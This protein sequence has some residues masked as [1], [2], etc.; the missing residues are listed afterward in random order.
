MSLEKT[1]SMDS[2]GLEVYCN[3]VKQLVDS[4]MLSLLPTIAQMKAQKQIQYALNTIGKRLRPTLVILC[5]ES[6][7]GKREKLRKL[8]L[9]FELLHLAT[10]VH[11]DILDEDLFRRNALS[12]YAKWNVKN[13]ILVG[14]VLASLSLSLCK[15]YK[16]KIIEVMIDTCVQLSDGEFSDVAL[17]RVEL[18]EKDYFEKVKKK[19]AA[20]F[21]AAC[22]CGALAAGGSKREAETLRHF[23]ENYGIAY[24]IRD[25]ISDAEASD[26][27]LQPNIH[28]FR[29]TLPIIHA[30]ES[31]S[32][33]QQT[34]LTSLLSMK[35]QDGLRDFLDE[36]KSYFQN[37]SLDY[38]AERLDEYADKATDS[39]APLKESVFKGYLVEML[40][41]LRVSRSRITSSFQTT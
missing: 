17:A 6:V 27:D 3:S 11:D 38:C 32:G 34:R 25:D 18:N 23:G 21:A 20:L 26:S 31:A 7:G 2:V 39:L 10:L 29:A 33:P 22:Q 15:N 9:A 5:G 8:A 35:T 41:N 36:T 40:E 16:R 1:S 19:C 30:F 28:R 37:G 14:D 24:Q 4:E 12:V 13:A